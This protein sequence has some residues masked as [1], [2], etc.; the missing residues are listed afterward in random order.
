MK[1]NPL[2]YA[3]MSKFT[4]SLKTL[5]TLLDIDIDRVPGWDSFISLFFQLQPLQ[6]SCEHFDPRRSNTILKEFK[7]LMHPND[8]NQ[9]VRDFKH[10]L[11]LLL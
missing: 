9:T 5:E 4:K 6:M 11:K 10:D 8:Y 3:A 7:T 1:R 2:H